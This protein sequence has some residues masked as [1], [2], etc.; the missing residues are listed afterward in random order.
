MG[1]LFPELLLLLVPAAWVWWWSRGRDPVTQLVRG[2][3]VVLIGLAV[4]GPY[5][6]T[7][8]SGRDL[9][10]VMDRSRSM[11]AEAN[12][13]ALE[14]IQHAEDLRRDLD[15]VGVVSFG[16]RPAVERLLSERDR[17]RGFEVELDPDGSDLGKALEAALELV[18]RGRA[19]SLLLLSDG[20]SNGTDPIDVA[21]R[22][23]ARGVRIDV[24]SFPLPPRADLAIERIE[25]PDEVAEGEPFQFSV[26]VYADRATESEFRL[27]RGQ[28]LL[29]NGTRRFEAG[30]NRL[31]FRD[32]VDRPGT[33]D[34]Q[35][36]LRHEGDRIP[37]ND[38]GLGATQ[39]RGARSI[40]LLNGDGR[41]DTLSA[42]LER[43]GLRVEVA[44][45]E[46]ARL[47]RMGL[48]AHRAVILQN[49]SAQR[50]QTHLESLRE[51]VL[52]RG[53]GLLLTGGKASFGMGGY[54]KSVI[55]P[56]L[57]VSTEMRQEHRKQAIAL[58]VALDRSGS[59][60]APVAGGKTKMDLANLGTIA[61][62]ELL[63]PID[64]VGVIAV[65][66][67]PHVIQPLIAAE[68]TSALTAKVRRIESMGGGI[69]TYSAL[70]AAGKQ[71]EDAT[72]PNRHI[73]LFADAA[74]A[75]EQEK[76]PELLHQFEQMGIT[77]SVIALG[78]P[79][80]VDAAFL[81][82]VARRGNGETYFTT[83]PDDL[84]RLFAMD[85]MKAA[86]AVF[87]EEPSG[88]KTLPDFFTLGELNLPQFPSLPGYNLTYLR[89]G[90][91]AG[92]VTLDS[93]QAPIFAFHYQGIGRVAAF[94]GQIGGTFGG[95][96][97][98]WEGF[99]TYFTTIARWLAGQEEPT[100]IFPSVR[101]EGR[102]AIVSVEIDP[103]SATPPDTSKLEARVQNPDGSIDTFPLERV[104]QDRFEARYPLHQEGITLGTLRMGE[105]RFVT[106][107]P[108]SLPY[109][110]EYERSSDP[111]RGERL[112][113]AIARESGG[114]VAPSADALFRGSREGTQTRLVVRELL[115]AALILLLVEIAGRRLQL[116]NSLRLPRAIALPA[117]L[118]AAVARWRTRAK[119]VERAKPT[120]RPFSR[121]EPGA[122]PEPADPPTTPPPAPPDAPRSGVTSALARAKKSAGRKLDR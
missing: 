32:V 35:V 68:D 119:S 37:E 104:A 41:P 94:T 30:M 23:Y 82:E 18:P 6:R 83:R 28:H 121:E 102:D 109:S 88:V 11:P 53:G 10:V 105:R 16:K 120:G 113:R 39:V 61:A 75:E 81:R 9:L 46:A 67:S 52:E 97:V 108:V 47:D 92:A 111:E 1:F 42:V 14:L 24:R 118:R 22:A 106:L 33:A 21:R 59:M 60:M 64:S 80:D 26:W 71:L 34:Y 19:A 90:A 57:P 103:D 58:V 54:F 40:L 117:A 48:T 62:I 96:L 79:G 89:S 15:R 77:V 7:S 78:T 27:Q 70:L 114:E 116:W 3:I 56:I 115:L 87:V 76:C 99:A 110:P 91:I 2:L 101:R 36:E 73:I 44:T 98:A 31:V 85:T 51:F 72:Q 69:F 112:L 45:P 65:D 74:D 17:F 49:V 12:K 5:Y 25:L 122:A 38:R 43:A 4:A 63:S 84:P 13:S 29:S 100:D 8:S 50:I 66:S 107:P 93:Y 86:R 55:D 20:E 95:P